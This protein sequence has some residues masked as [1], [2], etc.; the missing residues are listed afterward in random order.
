VS[1]GSPGGLVVSGGTAGTVVSLAALEAAAQRL[2]SCSL[3]VA[4]IGGVLWRRTAL[5]LADPRLVAGVAV[6][7]PAMVSSLVADLA[8]AQAEIAA[9]AGPTGALGESAELAL[10]GTLVAGAVQGYRA[11]EASVERSWD[12]LAD[13]TMFAVGAQ[14]PL[15]ALA[16]LHAHQDG[17]DLLAESDVTAFESPWLVELAARGLDGFL[18]GLGTLDPVVVAALDF[19]CAVEGRAFT[20][21]DEAEAVGVVAAAGSL[22]GAFDESRAGPVSVRQVRSV[23]DVAGPGSLSDLV[24]GPAALER[25]PD[26]IRVTEVPQPDGSSAWIVQI[27]GT[28]DWSPHAG[29]MPF[30]LTS[31][32]RLMAGEATA[33]TV[34]VRLALEAAQRESA[35]RRGKGQ[36]ATAPRR[37]PVLLAGH[38]QGGIVAASL[39]SDPDFT[40][41]HAVTDVVAFGAP[42][43]RF[44][45]PA[46][47]RVLAVEHRQDPV[48]RLDGRANPDRRT[49]TTVVADTEVVDASVATGSAAHAGR[50]YRRSAALVDGIPA[51][52]A[53]SVDEWRSGTSRYLV[54]AGS[55][56][57]VLREYHAQRGWQNPTP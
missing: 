36:G 39:A 18:V 54:G 8:R 56:R 53:P 16:A 47:V 50:L 48:T 38:S 33:A 21:T 31:D 3:D 11:V 14:L 19:A 17:H 12:A 40:A 27:P 49:W 28:Q 46:S 13:V 37:E 22:L 35:V 4:E 26:R 15:L 1:G 9:L 20:P 34:A 41:A 5:A 24:L 23:E 6:A 30:D 45:I 55:E 32:V 42:I 51:G 10:L 25:E 44:P 29:S 57:T 2:R 52:A 7:D 43:A